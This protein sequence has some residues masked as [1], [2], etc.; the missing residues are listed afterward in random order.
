MT[1]YCNNECEAEATHFYRNQFGEIVAVCWTCKTAFEMGQANPQ[2][3][4]LHVSDLPLSD[5]WESEDWQDDDPLE[6]SDIDPIEEFPD[7]RGQDFPEEE[8]F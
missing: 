5:L 8:S 6:F 4:L 7:N 2:A 3:R 1:V